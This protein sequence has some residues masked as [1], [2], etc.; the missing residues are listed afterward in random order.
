VARFPGGLGWPALAT[1]IGLR[2]GLTG[3]ESRGNRLVN[4]LIA[5]AVEGNGTA[6]GNVWLAH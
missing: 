6:R 3:N 1:G 2:G 4:N 5:L